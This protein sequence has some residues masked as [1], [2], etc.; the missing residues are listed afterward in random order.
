MKKLL[1][2][3]L[4]IDY[5][6]FF[7]LALIISTLIIWIF[8][9]VNF[10]DIMIEDGRDYDVYI[11][12]A[13]L[14]FPKILSRLLPFVLFFSIYFILTRY[15]QNNE[16]IIFWNFGV[17]K[18]QFVNFIL[19]L[20]IFLLVIQVFLTNIIVPKSLNKAR[21][22][23]SNSNIDFVGNFIKPK[24]FNDTIKGVT[25][26][27]EKNDE[28]GFLYNLYIKKNIDNGFELTYA[29]KGI[30]TKKNSA[31]VLILYDGETTRNI[32]QKLT[33]FNFSKSD[34]LLANLDA[35]TVTHPKTQ[36]MNTMDILLCVSRL[37]KVTGA[38]S[39]FNN[40]KKQIINCSTD[41]KL[42][43]L[44]ELYKRLIVPFY[45][46]ILM[47]IPYLL[48]FTSKEKSNYSKIKLTA[49]FTGILIIIFSEGVIRFVSEELF[50]NF[51]I[52]FSPFFIFFIFYLSF[53]FRLN[54]KT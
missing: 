28:D 35:N 34:F 26:Y 2:R 31:P 29:K 32:N 23:L 11:S 49:F 43:L 48:I 41:N 1:Y 10:L 12:Y 37:Y 52:L 53:I 18:V 27:S 45:I 9:A 46:P 13:L 6:S 47:L 15:E 3:K 20:S 14:N 38:I 21:S 51:Y 24:R 17:N 22:F 44:K 16:L 54:S 50:R 19:K 33:N 40:K 30:F 5:M 8:Q 7:F 39:L 36:Q 4:F 42:V 25:I